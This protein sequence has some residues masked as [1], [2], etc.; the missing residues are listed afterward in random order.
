MEG[1]EN[2]VGYSVKKRLQSMDTYKD[3]ASQISA[4]EATFEAA[5]Q[6]ITKHYSKPGVTAKTVHPLFPDFDLWK[7]PFAQVIF[8]S[9][10]AVAGKNPGQQS[11][12]M[13]RAMIRG[14][15]DEN[16]EQFVAY[17]LPTPDTLRT[18]HSEEAEALEGD[19][20]QEYEYTLTREYNW[21]VKNKASKGYEETYFFV[22]RPA[23]G[24]FYNEIETRVQ[25]RKRRGRTGKSAMNSKLIVKHRDMTEDEVYAQDMRLSQLEPPV[26]EEDEEWGLGEG[27]EE[28]EREEATTPTS[29]TEGE[30][31]E[32]GDEGEREG[33]E[34]DEEFEQAFGS[35]EED[36]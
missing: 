3:R 30:G 2:K 23:E 28:E 16:N 14:M 8:D 27:E 18:R 31:R 22:V 15:M 12:E 24:I 7:L 10:P 29:P 36:D 25:L 20:E 9:D 6:P 13:S 34:R 1:A 33:S 26:L 32:E 5:K 21:N 4:I 11:K 35:G 17:F 19:H